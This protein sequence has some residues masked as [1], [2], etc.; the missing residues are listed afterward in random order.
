MRRGRAG[1][2]G[3]LPAYVYRRAHRPLS[4]VSGRYG[5][6]RAPS[7][8]RY[9]YQ[10][11]IPFRIIVYHEAHAVKISSVVL[12]AVVLPRVGVREPQEAAPPR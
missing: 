10:E 3:S 9:K 5:I 6:K 2:L 12:V 1:T 11:L 4:L 7:C 8:T